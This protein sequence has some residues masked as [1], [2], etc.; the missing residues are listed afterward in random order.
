MAKDDKTNVMRLL[1]AA[2]ISFDEHQYDPVT[3]DGELVAK[4][5]GTDPCATFK[6]LVT[7]SESRKYYVF[8]IPVNQE[9]DLKAC[10]RAVGEKSISMLP[11]K[12]LL[13]LTGYVHGGCSPIGMKKTFQT[14]LDSSCLNF[15]KITFS[16]GKLGRQVSVSPQDM[17][18]YIGASTAPLT[19][20]K[21]HS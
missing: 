13:P 5:L 17:I 15:P 9:L 8:V 3:T 21:S 18:A 6:T 16:A 19:R 14:T 7:V 1:S 11:Q 4:A 2:G 12:N 20:P 10:A